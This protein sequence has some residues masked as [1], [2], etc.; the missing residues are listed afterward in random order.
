M[1]VI[2]VK[3]INIISACK[4]ILALQDVNTINKNTM[5]KYFGILPQEAQSLLAL[6]N[7]FRSEGAD[8][9]CF[10]GYY[11]GYSIAQTGK[12]FDLC[13]LR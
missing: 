4:G 9:S 6:I 7:I 10:N 5:R 12:E 11:I 2:F 13:A 1:G 8:F 3:P